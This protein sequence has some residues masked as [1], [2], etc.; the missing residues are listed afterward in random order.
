MND[1]DVVEAFALMWQ[2]RSSIERGSIEDIKN[3]IRFELKDEFTHPR[4]RR[5]PMEKYQFAIGR[6]EKLEVVQDIKLEL[7]RLYRNE[8]DSITDSVNPD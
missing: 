1:K 7:I 6:I 4:V 3:L 8:L 5:T 2:D